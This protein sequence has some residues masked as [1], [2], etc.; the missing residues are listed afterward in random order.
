MARLSV[1]DSLRRKGYI[2]EEQLLEAN[3]RL[4][5]PENVGKKLEDILVAYKYVTDEQMLDV[6]ALR[7]GYGVINLKDYKVDEIAFKKIP[8]QLA[9]SRS[10]IAVSIENNVLVIALSDPND[11]HA[12]EDIKSVVKMPIKFRLGLKS[13]IDKILRDYYSEV[14]VQ[15]AANKASESV[16][17]VD[18]TDGKGLVDDSAPIVALVNSILLKGYNSGASDIHI[19]PF[20]KQTYVRLRIDG[21]L[22]DYI[23]VEPKLHSSIVTRIKVMSD[24]DIAEKRI[25]Q[26][27]HTKVIL[28]NKLMNIRVSTLPMLAGEKIVMRFLNTEAKLDNSET[29]GMNPYNYEKIKRIMQHPNGVIYI[30]GPTGSGKTTTLYMM[31]DR[32][33]KG[34]INVSTIED[35]VER[36]LPR[37]NQTQVNNQAGMTFAIG[38]RALLRQDPDVILVGETRDGETA[39]IAVTAAITGHLVLS[40]LHTNDA[41]SSITRLEDMGVEYYLLASAL[42]GVVAQRLM[43]KICPKCREKYTPTKDDLLILQEDVPELWRGKGCDYCNGTGY[44]GRIAIHEILEIDGEVRQLISK[45]R[46]L[47]EVYKYLEENDFDLNYEHYLFLKEDN[48]I[49]D[50]YVDKFIEDEVDGIFCFNDMMALDV[51]RYLHIRNIKVPEQ[52]KVIGYDNLD[53][54][55]P[56]PFNLTSVGS[57]KNQIIDVALDLLFK[58][59]LENRHIND[60]VELG[61]NIV[62][63]ETCL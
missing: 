34:A 42:K 2:T 7:S 18:D 35:P 5:E 51:I 26:D 9:L 38:L 44:K 62:L 37:I 36:P 49:I 12:I 4:K 63:K 20:E 55:F 24:L 40:T 21:Q 29:F 39:S 47:E 15:D 59:I 6:I 3:Q 58:Q 22:I 46:P 32:V 13:H 43:K 41:V 52:I 16:Q 30:T 31:M 33:A 25:P 11:L 14:N 61:I 28:D 10:V 19:E 50:K 17:T 8:K 60:A 23:T 1:E 27:G 45:N 53:E 54:N 57:N 56:L 48:E